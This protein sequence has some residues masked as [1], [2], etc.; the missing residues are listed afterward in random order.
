MYQGQ[1]D[2]AQNQR[3]RQKTQEKE[4]EEIPNEL[5]QLLEIESRLQQLSRAEISLEA[6]RKEWYE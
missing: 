6:L 5:R 3:G 2:G 1:F 4:N